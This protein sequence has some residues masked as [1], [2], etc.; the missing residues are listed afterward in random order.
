MPSNPEKMKKFLSKISNRPAPLAPWNMSRC[1]AWEER[2]VY[3]TGLALLAGALLLVAGC[4]P[5]VAQLTSEQSKAFDSAPPEVKQMWEKALAADKTNDY[6]TAA[7][8]LDSLQKMI[9]S[10]PQTQALN[11]ERDAFGE[12]LMKAAG[13]NDPAAIQAVLNDRKSKTR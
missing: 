2:G 10:D 3:S 1:R 13:K 7:A 4:G 9:L 5:K 8:S 11:A 12:R 6:V